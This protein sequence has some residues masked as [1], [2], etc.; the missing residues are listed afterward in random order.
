MSKN[1]ELIE[2]IRKGDAAAVATLLDE[3]RSLLQAGAGP[4]SAM[5]LAVYH[6][7]R[8]IAQLFLDR[9]AEPAF[10]EAVA[11]GDKERVSAMLADHPSLLHEFTPDGFPP[12]GLAIF[13]RHPDLARDLIERGADVSA[14]AR[15]AQRV[16]P[17]HAA[18]SGGD[19][20]SMRLLLSRG[21]DPNARQQQGYAPLHASAINDDRATAEVL[22]A[23][24]ADPNARNDDGKTPAD[25]AAQGG[26]NDLAEWLRRTPAEPTTP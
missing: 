18:A 25:F 8:D 21:P 4:V 12:A 2:S 20:A 19:T 5:L 14:A 10:G 23:H 7:R 9:G 26:H 17:V 24:G 22:L 3:D 11:L 1:D 16:A 6:G 13:F 15:N